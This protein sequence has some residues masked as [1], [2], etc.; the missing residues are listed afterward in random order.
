[1]GWIAVNKDKEILREFQEDGSQLYGRPVEDGESGHLTM[2]GQQDYGHN[3]YVDLIQGVIIIDPKNMSID[4]NGM[5]SIEE[6]STILWVC[7]ETN[8][9]GEFFNAITSEPDEEGN[10]TIGYEPLVW[11]PIWF[12]RHTS[13]V[14]APTKVIGAQTTWEGRNIKKVVSLFPDGRIGIY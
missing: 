13:G 2:I 3:I 11:R 1:M 9:I 7:E 12:S 5:M 10:F 4:E 14:P 6:A 8:I